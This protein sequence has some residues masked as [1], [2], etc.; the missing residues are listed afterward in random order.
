MHGFQKTLKDY[1][2][3][4][5][6]NKANRAI[7]VQGKFERLRELQDET[8]ERGKLPI[9]DLPGFEAKDVNRE[10]FLRELQRASVVLFFKSEQ[11]NR[12][13]GVDDLANFF[14]LGDIHTS[15]VYR[16]LLL[17]VYNDRDKSIQNTET[18]KNEKEAFMKETRTLFPPSSPVASAGS[19]AL[20]NRKERLN[21]YRVGAQLAKLGETGD[22]EITQRNG[23]K[24]EKRTIMKTST[25]CEG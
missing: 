4:L 2:S 6:E 18:A 11:S 15:F 13:P 23:K 5:S 12:A 22:K 7:R 16:P 24:M 20:I 9:V 19:N 3:K 21:V 8:I 10:M 25:T 1:L 14:A 17:F